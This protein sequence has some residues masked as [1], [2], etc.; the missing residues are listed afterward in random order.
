MLTKA[1]RKTVNLIK[2]NIGEE[3]YFKYQLFK[4]KF[5][6]KKAL[7]R[8]KKKETINICFFL[9][10]ESVWKYEE[11][12][13]LFNEDERFNPLILVCP[14]TPYG[15]ENMLD[16]MEKAYLSFKK[17]NYNVIK[18][19]K[20]D[21]NWIN[22][23]NELKPDFIFFTNPHELTKPQY[24]IRNFRGNLTCYVPYNFGNSHMLEMFHN[25]DFHNLIWKLFAETEIH[26]KYSIETARNKGKNV[27]VTGFPGTDK[28]LNTENSTNYKGIWKHENTKKII[29]A[30]HHTIDDDKSFISFS[31]FLV[32]NEFMLELLNKFDNQIEIIF[33]PHPLLKIK[34]YNHKDWGKEKT[35]N[36]YN[37]WGNHSY[38]SLN[39][40]DYID[41]FKTSNAMIHDSGSFL[42]EYLYVKKP[43]LRTDKDDTITERLNSFGKMAYKQ[44]YIAKNTQ[45]IEDFIKNVLLKGDDV[46]KKERLSFYE[47]YL[48][49]P[50]NNTASENIYNFI[51]NSLK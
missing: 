34:L 42:I 20:S 5:L 3:K 17:K 18:S 14:Y 23:K 21:G 37:L 8:V 24:Y 27:E 48:V 44:H 26:K 33:K 31:S 29:W 13:K 38:G 25:Q 19:L 2:K 40:G 32:Y 22:V 39:E 16:D 9:I 45:D 30:P 51:K 47:K 36:Y 10:H 46:M 41:L 49:P 1:I 12:Y 11:L 4:V 15:E 6:H 28:F 7:N 43:V 35:D 50:S